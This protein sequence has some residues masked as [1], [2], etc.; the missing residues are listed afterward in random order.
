MGLS[1]MELDLVLKLV[2]E[3]RLRP[4]GRVAEI[5]AQQ[6]SNDFLRKQAKIDVIAKELGITKRL[7]L[8]PPPPVFTLDDYV[9]LGG[10]KQPDDAPRSEVFWKWMGLE[11]LAVDVDNSEGTLALDLNFDDVP[12]QHRGKYDL[13]INAGTTEHVANQLNAMKVI[14]DLTSRDGVM[15]HRLP[16]QGFTNHGLVN[17]NL[18]FFWML[19][20]SNAYKWREMDFDPYA[21]T[22]GID[23][24][25]IETVV[26]FNPAARKKLESAQIT[27][28]AVAVAMEKMINIDFI[29]PLDVRT[30][31]DV[32]VKALRDR[33]WTVFDPAR[34]Q[35][36]IKAQRGG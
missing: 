9:R 7:D 21:R 19:A 32:N 31:E 11:Y 26:Q 15:V 6:L 1:S 24:D 30:G 4:G 34:L 14:H 16:G 10:E 23:K 25:I 20:R 35:R 8:P 3:K 33:Y 2:R 28:A 5:G 36:E 18:K 27:E 29:P 22:I 17:Y 13:V 12:V